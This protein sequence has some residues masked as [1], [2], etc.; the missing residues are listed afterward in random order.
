ML[1]AQSYGIFTKL[2]LNWHVWPV[3]LSWVCLKGYVNSLWFLA[4]T[5]FQQNQL[6]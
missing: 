2:I 3:D 6:Y 4:G 1:I 5:L